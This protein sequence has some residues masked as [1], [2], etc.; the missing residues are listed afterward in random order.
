MGGV[1][2]RILWVG[3]NLA[4]PPNRGV[5]QR[6]YNLLRQA[7]KSCE[8]HVLAFDQPASRPVDVSQ[9]DCV[10][11]LREFCA[12]VTWVGMADGFLASN[13]Y[14]LALRGLISSD[15][16]EIH[17]MRSTKMAELLRSM[18]DK[19]QFDV[20]H[21]DTIALAQYRPL[22]S[23]CGT[24]LN[25]HNIESSMMTRRA[26]NES[27]MLRRA[28][29]SQHA[30]KL[31]NLES[32]WCP[33]FD[34]NLVVSTEDRT[35]L[36]D[37]V[38]NLKSTVVPNGTDIEYFTA[39]PDPGGAT[40]LFCGG[41]DW[42]PNVDAVRYFFNGIW[43]KLL[44]DSPDVEIYIVGRNPPDWLCKLASKDIRLHVTGF[45][46]DA[47]PFFRKATA[48]VCPI[49]DGGGTRLKILD[50]F[51][52][53][54]PLIGT[55]FACSGLSLKDGEHV[56]LADSSESF[57][58]QIQRIFA[59]SALRRKLSANARVLVEERY[60]WDVVGKSLIDSYEFAAARSPQRKIESTAS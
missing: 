56:L 14:L 49:A 54:V 59:D 11:A 4:Y 6:N 29:W 40:L 17:W 18:L 25:H 32:K 27:S 44:R 30:Q 55:S 26:L 37:A 42:Y 53:G 20:V 9:A 8:I 3:H 24:V 12:D 21:F 10:Q 16:Y 13:R 52:M 7:A 60:S 2:L 31:R 51:A 28:Y 50:A 19:L 23:G 48:Y 47:R 45:V 34:L 58:D 22:V 1:V 39:R 5:L 15:P 46:E 57:V 35:E 38:P 41:L 33:S 36:T 43:P